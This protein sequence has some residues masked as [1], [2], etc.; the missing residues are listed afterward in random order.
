[1]K[2]DFVHLIKI[3]VY[4]HLTAL[5]VMNQNLI[6][7]LGVIRKIILNGV[8]HL[9]KV[10]VHFTKILVKMLN[11]ITRVNIVMNLK[12]IV[13]VQT[14][15]IRKIM[16]NGVLILLNIHLSNMINATLL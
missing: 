11:M 9:K 1:M 14:S 13:K 3:N 2:M 6:V 5:G 10:F 4:I 15:V 16:L 12:I 8:Q 7:K